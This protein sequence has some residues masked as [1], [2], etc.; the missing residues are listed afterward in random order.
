MRFLALVTAAVAAQ[1]TAALAQNTSDIQVTGPILNFGVFDVATGSFSPPL[2][3]DADADTYCFANAT[4]NN[5]LNVG[6]LDKER[7]DWATFA[8]CMPTN[9][10]NQF[11]VG[12]ATNQPNP[13]NCRIRFYSGTAGMCG[14]GGVGTKGTLLATYDINGLPGSTLPA[15]QYQGKTG[16]VDISASTF[17]LPDGPFGYS[18]QFFDAV[19]GPL[20]VGPPNPAGDVNNY[21]RYTVTTGACDG[22]FAGTATNFG[23]YYMRLRVDDG[24]VPCTGGFSQYG[25]GVGGINLGTLNSTGSATLGSSNT[26]VGGNPQTASSQTSGQMYGSLAQF[27]FPVLGGTL[28]IDPSMLFHTFNKKTFPGLPGSSVTWVQII[29]NDVS[30]IGASVDYQALYICTNPSFDLFRF[31][32]GLKLTVCP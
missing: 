26:I 7:L 27:S 3:G 24:V 22:T 13:I 1:A 32:N 2:A 25:V 8:T 9:V 21:D 10:V 14:T 16:M 28:L 31:T 12:Y 18:Y 6:G 15:G 11:D 5:N 29:P 20:R 4:I 19:S 23:S 17:T 30:L